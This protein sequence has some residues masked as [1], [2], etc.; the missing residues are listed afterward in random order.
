MHWE[1]LK[2]PVIL[3]TAARHSL[4]KIISVFTGTKVP[5]A[6]SGIEHKL[7]PIP[8]LYSNPE[9]LRLRCPQNLARP[10]RRNWAKNREEATDFNVSGRQ[11]KPKRMGLPL[12]PIGTGNSRILNRSPHE[13]KGEFH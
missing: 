1:V 8:R 5:F 10:H 12:G 6:V 9:F 2:N 13:Q 11:H 7:A 3:R 4:T